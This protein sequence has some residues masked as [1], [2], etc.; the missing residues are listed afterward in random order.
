MESRPSFNIVEAIVIATDG[1]EVDITASLL[2]FQTF[3]HIQKPYVDASIVFLDDF[4]LKDTLSVG[5]T[6]RFR[7]LFGKPGDLEFAAYAKFFYIQQIDDTSRLNERAEILAISLV[8]EHLFIDSIKQ[9]S[10]SYSDTFENMIEQIVSVELGKDI[11]KNKFEGSAQ[12]IR[13]LVVPYMSPLEAVNWIK[14]RA[15]T[16]TGGPL[17]LYSSLYSNDL[18]L[19]DFD[20]LMKEEPFNT[21]LPLRYSAAANS[22]SEAD[23]AKRTY[24]N[25][26][27]FKESGNDNMMS[28]Y[29]NG[30]IG[31]LYTN[32][33]AGTGFIGASHISVRDIVNEFYATGV[34]DPE[35]AQNVYDPT[36]LIQG[37]LSDEYN[38]A[39]VFQITSTKTYNQFKSYHDEATIVEDQNIIE[40]KLK[41]KNKIIRS[42][43][44]K[45][46]IDIGMEGTLFFEAGCGVG[47]KVR[48]LFL[49]SNVSGDE[50]D[51]SDQIDKSKSGDY[52]ILAINHKFSEENHTA[53]LRLSKVNGLPKNFVLE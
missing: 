52:F 13:K 47:N 27:S 49:Q 23:D 48:V 50:K 53:S 43:L 30:N 3:E 21:K 39:S 44:K 17:Y 38:S 42:I 5:G 7:I 29:E 51:A 31:S 25:I 18:F 22:A 14:D 46:V 8:E 16:R 6:E 28:M 12:G 37:K 32:V 20:S 24:Y 10:R 1:T 15:T 34:I 35:T 9:L 4:G 11:V 2:E 26:I 19:S 45:N 33:D 40:S 41:I 36:L